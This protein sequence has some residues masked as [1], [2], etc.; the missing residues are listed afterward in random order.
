MNKRY[1]W[2]LSAIMMVAMLSVG[3]SSCKSDDEEENGP[4]T[5]KTE[6]T[7][8][9]KDGLKGYWMEE[10]TQQQWMEWG[11][12]ACSFFYLDGEGGG[13][14]YYPDG[15]WD[16][17]R[18]SIRYQEGNGDNYGTIPYTKVF[19]I[20]KDNTGITYTLYTFA[21]LGRAY[22]EE[23]LIYTQKGTTIV[24]DGGNTNKINFANGSLV[25]YKRVT[26]VN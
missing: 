26:I 15:S 7:D 21:S 16:S 25:G 6:K 3:L 12:L 19:K 20:V 11:N 8:Y 10:P 14:W 2:R 9:G 17:Y 4:E 22:R 5:E 13:T 23:P 1:L 24:I 18:F